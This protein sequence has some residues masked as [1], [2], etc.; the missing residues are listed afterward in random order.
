[1]TELLIL[2]LYNC[3]FQQY[4]VGDRLI[5]CDELETIWEKVAL[6]YF[7]KISLYL[8]RGTEEN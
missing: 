8:P 4:K 7:K 2:G 6:A 1:M 5:V 3:T